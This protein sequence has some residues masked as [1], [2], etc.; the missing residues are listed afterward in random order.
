VGF[1]HPTMMQTLPSEVPIALREYCPAGRHDD[2]QRTRD[3]SSN[4]RG[5]LA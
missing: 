5:T 4:E 2:H 3:P 1:T